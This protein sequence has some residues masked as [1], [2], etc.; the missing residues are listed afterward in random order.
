MDLTVHDA[1]ALLH[2]SENTVYRWI[3]EGT[4]PSYRIN[5][6]YRLNRVD[7][8]EWATARNIK[9]SPEIFSSE[10]PQAPANVLAAKLR[11]GG[12]LYDLPGADKLSALK[13]IC[14]ALPLPAEVNRQ[15]L[16]GVLL[17]R[18]ALGSTAI[19][20]GIAIPHPRSP[21]V[22]NVKDPLVTLAFLKQPV[23]FAALD[24]RPVDTLFLIISTTIR[25]HLETLSH[26]MFALQN[27]GFVSLLRK[28][29]SAE[30]IVGA[31]E[32]IETGLGAK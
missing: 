30:Q 10:Q 8:L 2:T 4:L 26:L 18:E 17:A 12:V 9:L 27:E 21:L 24:G 19:G 28:R 7:L 29:A 5:D 23:D 32:K 25:G 1:A 15:D 20:R 14:D 3:R 11:A 13:A 6:K 16:Y 22:L 31:M